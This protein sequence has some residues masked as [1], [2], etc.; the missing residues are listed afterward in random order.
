MVNQWTS[1]QLRAIKCDNKNCLVEAGAGSGKTAVIVEKYSRL[2][3][4]RKGG[5]R[6]LVI[7]FTLKATKE[8]KDRIGAKLLCD[9]S[10]RQDLITTIHGFCQYVINYYGVYAEMLPNGIV[11]EEGVRKAEIVKKVVEYSCRYWER[12]HCNDF[13]RLLAYFGYRNLSKILSALFVDLNNAK[14]SL[15]VSNCIDNNFGEINN[16]LI[17]LCGFCI[18]YYEG[19][20]AKQNMYTFDRLLGVVREMLDVAE[21]RKRLQNDFSHI[22]IDEFQDTDPL[23]WEIISMICGDK[24]YLEKCKL[25]IVGDARQSIYGFRGADCKIFQSLLEKFSKEDNCEVVRL[26][27]NFRTDRSLINLVNNVFLELS[28]SYT[29][30]LYTRE[31]NNFTQLGVYGLKSNDGQIKEVLGHVSSAKRDLNCSWSDIAILCRTNKEI[32]SWEFVLQS[33]GIPCV[34]LGEQGYWQKDWVIDIYMLARLLIDS[35]DSQAWFRMLSGDWVGMGFYEIEKV[36]EGCQKNQGCMFSNLLKLNVPRLGK[37]LSVYS[38]ARYSLMTNPM[39][40][41]LM[42]CMTR[43]CLVDELAYMSPFFDFLVMNEHKGYSLRELIRSMFLLISNPVKNAF[44]QSGKDGVRLMTIHASKGLEFDLVVLPDSHKGNQQKNND[45]VSF[46][47]TGVLLNKFVQDSVPTQ[48]SLKDQE[49]EAE[50]SEHLR[51]LYVALTRAKRRLFVLGLDDSKNESYLNLIQSAK[52]NTNDDAFIS[53]AIYQNDCKVSLQE[54]N[55]SDLHSDLKISCSNLDEEMIRD[56]SRETILSERD[57]LKRRSLYPTKQKCDHDDSLRWGE[58]I[59]RGLELKNK[60]PKKSNEEIIRHV[61]QE[62]YEFDNKKAFDEL[63]LKLE[64]YEKSVIYEM[65]TQAKKCLIEFEIVYRGQDKKILRKRLDL[66]F[67]DG[68]F[69]TIVDF[70]TGLKSPNQLDDYELALRSYLGD[71]NVMIKSMFYDV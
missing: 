24:C 32:K 61:L 28:D 7:T 10:I 39:S 5:Q 54:N 18:K 21:V 44:V 34:G 19:L 15:G 2:V 66:A 23:Q 57:C 71:K 38:D 67:F 3:S 31:S 25:F 33:S 47:K 8:L 45:P 40:E 30:L 22:I 48:L 36:F 52:L 55:T 29:D 20:L 51:L 56:V 26:R 14:H 1:E 41:V 50:K 17:D 4:A 42:R 13:K 49:K 9:S 69:W 65:V 46:S 59:H 63:K 70:K 43:L 62:F 27:E 37:F 58:L 35:H 6:I 12:Y 11:L 64:N 53:S 60:T 68:N 16:I